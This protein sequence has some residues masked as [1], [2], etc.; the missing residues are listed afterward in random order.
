MKH[1]T[2][3]CQK[4]VFILALGFGRCRS[5]IHAWLNKNICVSPSLTQ[6]SLK[7][8]TGQRDSAAQ[9]VIPALAPTL[10]KS[11]QAGRSLCPVRALCYYLDRILDLRQKKELV[12]VSFTN[13]FDKATSPVTLSS[14]IKQTVI[15]CNELSDQ[16]SVTLHQ[17]KAHGVRAFAASE[18]FQSGASLEQLL[19]AYQWKT[20]NTF[21]QFYLK[22]VA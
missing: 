21:T 11:L 22:D 1:L 8:P 18:A 3:D 5:K 12:F 7:E 2:E 16:E 13:G 14:W 15:L 10:D 17:V 19:S 4:T 20:H 9:V 6:L